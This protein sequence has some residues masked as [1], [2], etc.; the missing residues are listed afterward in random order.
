MKISDLLSPAIIID[1][2][3]LDHNIEFMAAKAEENG[4]NL[5]PHIKTH[6]CIEI[7]NRQR[8]AG[9][10]GITVSTPAE[11]K[12]FAG[13][14][15]TDITYA[16]PLAPDKFATM[17]DL[18]KKVKLNLLVESF[19][20]V[21]RLVEFSMDNDAQFHVLLKVNCGNNRVGVDPKSRSAIKLAKRISQKLN[22]EGILAHAG[23]SYS[24]HSVVEIKRIAQHEQDIM[25]SFAKSLRSEGIEIGTVSIGSTPTTW[26]VDSFKE[27]ITEIRPGNYVFFD[28]TQVALGTCDFKDVALTVLASVISTSPGRVV[29]DAGATALSKDLG[30]THI[31]DSGGYGKIIRN[32]ETSL[33]EDHFILNSLSQEHGKITATS[34][35]SLKPGDTLRIFPNHSCLT[36]NLYDHYYVVQS[37]SVVDKWNIQR[38]RLGI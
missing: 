18:S 31:D 37:D 33:I 21:D 10:K 22:F 23:Q 8:T 16:V 15:F 17:L 2:E 35:H 11:A 25:I 34:E 29:I 30:P 1:V 6:K 38:Q 27:G 28:Y 20:T 12:A 19:E 32:Y 3:R 13:A 24:A 36:A 5:R 26:L 7:G 9:A 4:V 14:G